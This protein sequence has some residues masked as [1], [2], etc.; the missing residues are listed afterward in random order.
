MESPVSTN[1]RVAVEDL[2]LVEV[3][4]AEAVS[5]PAVDLEAVLV[6]AEVASCP[7]VVPGAVVA[8]EEDSNRETELEPNPQRNRTGPK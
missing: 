2:W 8:A 5:M 7:G 3:L 4:V 6:V 1:L